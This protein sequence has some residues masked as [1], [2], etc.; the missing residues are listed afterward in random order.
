MYIYP[1]FIFS[2]FEIRTKLNNFVEVYSALMLR[3]L[4]APLKVVAISLEFLGQKLIF[5]RNN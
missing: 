5:T 3:D 1:A 4:D 2:R